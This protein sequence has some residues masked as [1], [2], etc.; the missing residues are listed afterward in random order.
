MNGGDFLCNLLLEVET[1]FVIE[2]FSLGETETTV[3]RKVCPPGVS[4]VPQ[5]NHRI[6]FRGP[7]R[8]DEAGQR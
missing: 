8:G 4:L 2:L 1:K 3:A 7:A 6:D 5:R